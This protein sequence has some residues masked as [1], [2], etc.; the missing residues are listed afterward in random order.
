MCW[1][2]YNAHM[3]PLANCLNEWKWLE[4]PIWMQLRDKVIDHTDF[5]NDFVPDLSA[6]NNYRSCFRQNSLC[7]FLIDKLR[8]LM[9]TKVLFLRFH[10]NTKETVFRSF[11]MNLM[12]LYSVS[13][14]KEVEK[15]I[16]KLLTA[17]TCKQP[18]NCQSI[19]W[20]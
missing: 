18:E 9:G 3:H 15:A 1:F 4:I 16:T 6:G 19:Q 2:I 17:G 20:P 7:F 12:L 10:V 13:D 11:V 8:I 5:Y 14:M